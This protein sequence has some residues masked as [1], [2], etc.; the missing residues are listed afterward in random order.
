VEGEYLCL[1]ALSS[2]NPIGNDLFAWWHIV[3]IFFLFFVFL[4][5]MSAGDFFFLLFCL[6]AFVCPLL[7]WQ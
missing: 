5:L 3:A 7:G 4:S 2:W 6:S 1:S